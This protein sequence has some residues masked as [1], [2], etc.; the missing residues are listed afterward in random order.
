[1]VHS[2]DAL[3]VKLKTGTG[4]GLRMCISLKTQLRIADI[5]SVHVGD[6]KLVTVTCAF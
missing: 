2:I 1:M 4:L 5:P 6:S 3:T